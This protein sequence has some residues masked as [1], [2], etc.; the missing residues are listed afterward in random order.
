MGEI[1]KRSKLH[2]STMPRDYMVL[3]VETTGLDPATCQIVEFAAVKVI[4]GRPSQKI[5]TLV[6]CDRLDPEAAAV[7]GI[8]A[9]MLVGKPDVR[10]VIDAFA[11]FAGDLPILAHNAKFDKS[12][13]DRVRALPNDWID[14]MD[15][16]ALA[17]PGEKRSLEAICARLGVTNDRAHR[18]LSDCVATNECYVR[19]LRVISNAS[20]DGRDVMPRVNEFDES[21][22]FYGRTFAITGDTVPS[23]RHDLMQAIVNMGGTVHNSV[24]LDTDYLIVVAVYDGKPTDK[25]RQAAEYAPRTGI[26]TVDVT[27]LCRYLP[28]DLADLL[29]YGDWRRERP[30]S[31]DF[32]KARAKAAKN[33]QNIP[34][35]V[36]S[37]QYSRESSGDGTPYARRSHYQQQPQSRDGMGIASM[38]LG[39]VAVS[40][41]LLVGL[42][43]C[44]QS[45]IIGGVSP[46]SV[47]S[48]AMLV[49]AIVG[50]TLGGVAKSR[51]RGLRSP[52]ATAGCYL[53]GVQIVLALVGM[54]TCMGAMM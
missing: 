41:T 18:A 26:K 22:P 11:E 17:F 1:V 37:R 12:F 31:A 15:V 32:A 35:S 53:C 39:I 36:D 50:L 7:N 44:G 29:T 47:V 48:L 13:V 33:G 10:T 21:S 43:S 20:T 40:V 25:M 49:P 2:V 54:A 51:A 5:A 45:G 9:D 4:G 30:T 23:S 34:V 6:A 46:Y 52:M 8:T 14:T 38:V 3:D 19:M 27:D 28:R 24:R 42:A 16:A